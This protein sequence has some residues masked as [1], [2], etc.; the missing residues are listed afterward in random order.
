MPQGARTGVRV[1]RMS[2]LRQFRL[3]ACL[4]AAAALALPASAHAQQADKPSK[5][6]QAAKQKPAAPA[7]STEAA[8]G[9][10]QPNLLGQY[11][12]WG[13]Y[14]AVA[15]G[16]KVCFALGRPQESKTNPA[17]KP[18]DPT[19]MF[20]A[21]RPSENVRN[22]VSVTIGYSFKAGADATIEIGPAKFAM[23][24]QSDGA[25]IKNAAEE[26][27]MVEA[28]R[29]GSDLVVTGTSARG[30]HSTDRYTLKG[31]SQAL[32]RASQECK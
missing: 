23:Y 14:A 31:L 11:G 2:R 12:E 24:T 25:W 5:P 6:K 28:M 19:Y 17:G 29:K 8:L 1:E 21:S 26:G 13:A 18:R 9:G 10:A 15:A 16:S 30:T 3:A 27:R 32:D 7:S 20:I 22:E 4:T